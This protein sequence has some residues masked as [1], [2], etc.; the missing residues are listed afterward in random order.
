MPYVE[1]ESLR[2]RLA[3]EV[4]LDVTEAVGIASEVADAL[5]Y[6]HAA[7]VLHRDIKPENILLT[8]GARPRSRIS[9]SRGR[10]TPRER[11]PDRDR[12]GAG[13]PAAT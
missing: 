5:A 8:G 3:R 12:A 10:S 4:Q 1:G 9:A 2:A 7:G 13:H 6:A 11:A